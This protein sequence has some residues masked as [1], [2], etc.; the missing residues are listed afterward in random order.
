MP[1]QIFGPAGGLDLCR[2]LVRAPELFQEGRDDP[3]PLQDR[4]RRML[5]AIGV[6]PGKARF[7][8]QLR[9]KLPGLATETVRGIGYRLEV[10]A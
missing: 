3:P 2:K 10:T 7:C 4:L 9:Q 8:Q 5:G 6:K 1:D